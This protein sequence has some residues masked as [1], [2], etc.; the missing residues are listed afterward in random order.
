ML[1]LWAEEE[2]AGADFG[3]KR[4]DDR[5]VR[6]LSN[7]GS[8]PNLSTAPHKLGNMHRRHV[9][10]LK[11]VGRAAASTSPPTL[12]P[13]LRGKQFGGEECVT[14]C[15]WTWTQRIGF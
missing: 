7:L 9:Q 11:R 6:L 12:N 10:S 13:A 1:A 2:V 15:L 8:R 3:D 4:L 5:M 14:A